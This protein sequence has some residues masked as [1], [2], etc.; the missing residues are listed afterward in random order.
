MTLF[1]IAVGTGDDC[2]FI[3]SA[4]TADEAIVRARA[5]PSRDPIAPTTKMTATPT[6]RGQDTVDRTFRG[7]RLGDEPEDRDGPP[8]TFQCIAYDWRTGFWM[9]NLKTGALRD[10]SECAIGRTFHRIY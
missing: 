1:L 4:P 2:Y 6:S 5:L 9:K 7:P 3:L 8:P 10:V